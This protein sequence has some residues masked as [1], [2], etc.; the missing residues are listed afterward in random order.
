MKRPV[1]KCRVRQ[2]VAQHNIVDALAFH[3]QVGLTNRIRRWVELLAQQVHRGVRIDGLDLVIS[4]R[5]HPTGAG[6]RVIY[7]SDNTRCC[8]IFL[9]IQQ[10]GDHQFDDVARSE[11]LT[12]RLVRGFGEPAD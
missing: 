5:Q 7:I 10:Q 11:V 6:G 3:H 8:E 1:P 2:R 4:N 9:F 12:S